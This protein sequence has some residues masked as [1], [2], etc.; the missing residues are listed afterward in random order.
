MEHPLDLAELRDP[1]R[2]IDSAMLR[3][4]PKH[5]RILAENWQ[6]NGYN[7]KDYRQGFVLHFWLEPS[8][9]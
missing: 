1:S 8:L 9:C 7:K 5:W 2:V 4:S 6:A 3:V